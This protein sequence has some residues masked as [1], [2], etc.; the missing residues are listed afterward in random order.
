MRVWVGVGHVADGIAGDVGACSIMCVHC[1]LSPLSQGAG[2][3][4]LGAGLLLD[5]HTSGERSWPFH[6]N[7]Y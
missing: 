5:S 7:Y 2:S 4:E 3:R 6:Y 1:T